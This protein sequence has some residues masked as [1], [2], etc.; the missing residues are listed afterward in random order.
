MKENIRKLRKVPVSCI[1]AGMSLPDDLYSRDGKALLIRAGETVTEELITKLNKMGTK[2]NFVMTYE[3]SWR[4][5]SGEGQMTA[6]QRQQRAEDEAGYTELKESVQDLLTKVAEEADSGFQETEIV[7]SAV[8]SKISSTELGELLRCIDTPR[9]MDEGLQRHSLNVAF[10]NG[11]MA[12]WMHFSKIDVSRIVVGGLLHDVGKTLIPEEILM[13]ARELTAKEREVIKQHPVYSYDIVQKGF[14]PAICDMVRHH[15]EKLNGTGYPDGLTGDEISLFARIT[16]I[17]DVY[18][19]MVSARSYKTSRLPFDILDQM[20]QGEFKGLDQHL[21]AVF[22]R[23]MKHV[24]KRSEVLMVDG[25]VGVV[26]YIPPND[27]SHPIV[28]TEMGPRQTDEH[29]YC[30][31]V[32]DMFH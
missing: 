9:E 29:W 25:S 19:A 8:I 32:A 3:T 12:H 1:R 13:A 26:A 31:E 17:A 30:S 4:V 7:A 24:F 28:V 14:D 18:D 15:H 27:I 20:V 22:V 21:T 2:D 11:M 16:A 10:L 6:G 5:I 23:N